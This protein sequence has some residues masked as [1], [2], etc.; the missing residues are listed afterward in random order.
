MNALLKRATFGLGFTLFGATLA[1]GGQ[2]VASGQGG[3]GGGR[4]PMAGR[5]LTLLGSLDLSEDQQAQ[6][7]GIREE[8]RDQR[9]DL[10]GDRAEARELLGE[11]A[12]AKPDRAAF[13][14]LIDERMADRTAFL[15]AAADDLLDFHAS[16]SPEQRAE[17]VERAREGA[18]AKRR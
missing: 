11:L 13:H 3:E 16:L 5:I 14:T 17:L 9:D 18:E 1:I 2:A 12:K 7:K 8:L 10:R 6:L 15:H 4:A